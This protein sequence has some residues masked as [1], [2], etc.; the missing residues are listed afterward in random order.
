MGLRD[1]TDACVLRGRD[2]AWRRARV[3]NY[4][5]GVG[6]ADKGTVVKQQPVEFVIFPSPE[7]APRS[8]AGYGPCFAKYPAGYLPL[9]DNYTGAC[10]NL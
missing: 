4:P 5:A 2:G 9:F 6:G 3:S 8:F 10:C 7:E 1:A